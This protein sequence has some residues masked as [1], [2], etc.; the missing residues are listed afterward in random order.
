MLAA[1]VLLLVGGLAA[2]GW[3]LAAPKRSANQEL[4]AARQ[5]WEAARARHYMLRVR[6]LSMHSGEKLLLE[7]RDER[8]V[9]GWYGNGSSALSAGELAQLGAL[10]PIERLFELAE[11]QVRRRP[12]WRERLTRM[13]PPLGLWIG[14]PCRLRPEPRLRYDS[15]LGYPSR[16][17]VGVSPCALNNDGMEIRVDGVRTY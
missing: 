17:F 4:E 1:A 11:A 9:A 16:L 13:L 12:H 3:L 8:L 6:I 14:Q 10:L 7:V 5:R 15:R 2:T